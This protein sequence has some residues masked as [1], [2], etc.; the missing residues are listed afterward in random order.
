MLFEF[1]PGCVRLRTVSDPA[2]PQTIPN[3]KSDTPQ[4]AVC[5]CGSSCSNSFDFTALLRL[6][7]AISL[8]CRGGRAAPGAKRARTGARQVATNMA[9]VDLEQTLDSLSLQDFEAGGIRVTSDV[10]EKPGQ[11]HVAVQDIVQIATQTTRQNAQQQWTKLKHAHPEIASATSTFRFPGQRG[12]D[13]EVVD[14]ATALRIM[15]VM[16]GQAAS[17]VRLKA[18]VILVRFLGGA[19]L[20]A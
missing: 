7:A 6:G 3:D 2:P 8:K 11:P 17:K 19:G 16:P 1:A 14:I 20:H 9:G 15:M 4:F 13:A 5:D 18:S 10:S 12:R